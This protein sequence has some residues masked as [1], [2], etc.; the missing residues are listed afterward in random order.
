LLE[1]ELVC[2]GDAARCVHVFD[3]YQPLTAMCACV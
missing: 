1:D 2:A 3:A